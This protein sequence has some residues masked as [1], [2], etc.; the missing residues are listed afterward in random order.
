LSR[1]RREDSF[2]LVV[3]VQQK[4]APAVHEGQQVI[5]RS[6]AL[7]RAA[8][9][10]GVPVLLSEHCPDS[11]GITVPEL[12]A[13]AP[14]DSRMR[15]VFFS[16]ADQNE[17]LLRID[18]TGRRQAVL[19]GMEAHVCVMQSALGLGERGF[20]TFIVQDAV[21]SRR[22]TDCAAAIERMR[23]AGGSIVTAE[24]VMF[25]WLHRADVPEWPELLRIVKQD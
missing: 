6:T 7:V 19:A 24:M 8:R 25:E 16:C 5:A 9:L 20:E 2:L 1:L 15:K 10:L 22:Q 18:S 17:C 21:A 4:L 3:D 11:L 23:A 13:V 14:E 12:L